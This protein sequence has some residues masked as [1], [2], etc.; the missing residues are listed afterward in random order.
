MDLC[1]E[2]KRRICYG[3]ISAFFKNISNLFADLY[4]TLSMTN[5]DLF[6]FCALI[7]GLLFM[8][9]QIQI[10]GTLFEAWKEKSCHKIIST[11]V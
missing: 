1:F 8:I 6:I 2:K 7:I 11:V 9:F 10:I 3:I 5:G 4:P